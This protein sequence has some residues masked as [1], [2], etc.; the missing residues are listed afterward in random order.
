[1]A[2]THMSQ[3]IYCLSCCS[4]TPNDTRQCT[5]WTNH[6]KQIRGRG[7]FGWGAV[8]LAVPP[9]QLPRDVWSPTALPRCQGE[10]R[11]W[12]RSPWLHALTTR[13]DFLPPAPCPG[14]RPRPWE[15]QRGWKHFPSDLQGGWRLQAALHLKASRERRKKRE[16]KN[17]LAGPEPG[18]ERLDQLTDGRRLRAAGLSFI[19]IPGPDSS[20]HGNT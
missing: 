8:R 12:Q 19:L 15:G 11:K 6:V 4:R 10:G 9:A 20:C 7:W 3:G 1:M 18:A 17:P 16:E 2:F 13:P 14:S 5:T